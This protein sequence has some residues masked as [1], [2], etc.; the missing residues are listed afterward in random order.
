MDSKHLGILAAAFVAAAYMVGRWVVDTRDSE[1]GQGGEWEGAE[2]PPS[3]EPETTTEDV[4]DMV[5][6]P[7][8]TVLGL[9]RAPAKYA[10][11]IAAAEQRHSIPPTMLERLLYQECR[12]REDIITGRKTSPVGAQGIAQFMPATA[13][14]MGINPLDPA[15]AIDAAG[16]YLAQLHRMFGDWT[17]ALAAYNWGMG[18]VSRKGLANAP[19]ETR[20]YFTNILRD[21][22]AATGN[23]YA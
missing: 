18:N 12:W 23:Q 5:T 21:V 11:L 22:N 3:A 10:G 20:D 4:F 16:K 19:T 9:W 7:V 8:K 6:T 2:T 15:Q 14:E 1:A 13:A 17:R